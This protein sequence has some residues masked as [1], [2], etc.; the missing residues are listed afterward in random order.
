MLERFEANS[1]KIVDVNFTITD[2]DNEMLRRLSP[3]A[4]V[5][6]VY[7]GVDIEYW[8]EQKYA[9]GSTIGI[10]ATTF[11]WIHNV[12]GVMWFLDDVMPQILKRIPGFKLQLLGMNPP[13]ELM[14]RANDHVKILGFVKDIRPYAAQSSVYIVPLHVGS[15]IRIKILEAMAM[16]MPVVSTSVGAEGI[17]GTNG[18]HYLIADSAA[19]FADAIA[20]I[21]SDSSFGQRI[22]IAA[23]QFV[24]SRF[25]WEQVGASIE[26]EME[27]IITF[28]KSKRIF[29]DIK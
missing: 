14:N 3:H 2:V 27:R 17:G 5:V 7:P 13:P 10:L 21:I 8:C 25:R 20:M 23:R 29:Q 19:E 18:V 4:N 28:Q 15:G 6:T 9:K 22:G 12:N 11:S 24:E 1:A 26:S 16:G